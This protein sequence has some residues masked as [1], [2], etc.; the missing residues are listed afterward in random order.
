MCC[1]FL[2][3]KGATLFFYSDMPPRL[4]GVQ[5][6]GGY[7]TEVAL[8]T[9][10]THLG[11]VW[12]CSFFVLFVCG[13]EGKGQGGAPDPFHYVKLA[14]R[15][16]VSLS[17]VQCA[18]LWLMCVRVCKGTVICQGRSRSRQLSRLA[19][20]PPQIRPTAVQCLKL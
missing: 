18:L 14:R 20:A 3:L 19:V 12:R 11:F 10:I 9:P 4:G 17:G 16:F 5:S 8:P 2:G 1:A 13:V 7:G 15:T 6:E